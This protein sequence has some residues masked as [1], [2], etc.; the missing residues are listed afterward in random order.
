MKKTYITPELKAVY[1]AQTLLQSGSLTIDGNSGSAT[2]HNA[3]ATGAAMVK[4]DRG[5]RES[6]KVW[7]DDWSVT[8]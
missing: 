1:T 6:Y 7:D 5:S 3:D 8:R 2:F 4:G